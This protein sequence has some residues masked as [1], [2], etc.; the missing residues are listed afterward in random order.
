VSPY[1]PWTGALYLSYNKTSNVYLAD[2][3][4]LKNFR[5][6]YQIADAWWGYN[7]GTQ[8]L[9]YKNMQLRLRKFIA[10]RGL[11]KN[12]SATPWDK[13]S[14][15]DYNYANTAGL[16]AAFTVFKQDFYRT[17]FI[18]GF[19]RN[20]D[21]PQGF[22]ASVI[23]GWTARQDSFS[24]VRKRPYFGTEF[25]R[26]RYNSKGFYSTYTFRLGG[27][28][29]QKKLEDVDILLRVDHFTKLRKMSRQWYNRYFLSGSFAKQIN[30]VLNAPLFFNNSFGMSYLN[31]PNGEF[32]EGISLRSTIKTEAVFYNTRKFL[33][34]RMAPFIFGDVSLISPRNQPFSKSDLFSAIGA[35]VRTR[36]ENL[37]Y[38][39]I[40]LKGYYFPRTIGDTKPW[41]VELNSN[42][43]FKYNSVF[44]RRPDFVN[45]N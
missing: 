29:T 9:M 45:P 35:G 37:V 1:L 12:Y 6:G 23:A 34:F 41:R 38:G 21:V 22:S 16:L 19:G 25:Q 13:L 33:G 27:Y 39:T 44:I 36:N 31:S 28:Y 7:F 5:Y 40:E 26:N 11:Y 30:W 2:T 4:Y 17:N 20:E 32:R 42:I 43:R 24:K 8:R 3:P 18:Y 14:G 15:Y 10:L